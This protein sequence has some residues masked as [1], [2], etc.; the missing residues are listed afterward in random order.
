MQENTTFG[1]NP[2]YVWIK[3]IEDSFG[4][5]QR[6]GCLEKEA[7]PTSS[8]QNPIPTFAWNTEGFQIQNQTSPDIMS[9]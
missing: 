1:E 6:A 5:N 4:P 3:K 7:R 8:I 9:S 2:I